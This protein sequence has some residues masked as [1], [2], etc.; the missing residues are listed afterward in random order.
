MRKGFLWLQVALSKGAWVMRRVFSSDCRLCY[1][2]VAWVMRKGFLWLQIV[3]SK[4]YLMRSFFL[5]L[6]IALSKGYLMR[7]GFLWLQIALSKGCLMRRVFLW[8]QIALSKGCSRLSWAVLDWN[9]PSIE[10]YKRRGGINLT[11]KEGWHLFRMTKPVMEDFVAQKES[12]SWFLHVHYM[13]SSKVF[14]VTCHFICFLGCLSAA[15]HRPASV[16]QIPTKNSKL[17]LFTFRYTSFQITAYSKARQSK[18]TLC[19]CLWLTH[20]PFAQ[21]IR[22]MIYEECIM[23]N[24]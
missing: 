16:G 8:L 12:K 1:Q 4:G 6:Q 3:L 19:R 10:L 21:V 20:T 24:T 18:E 2:R 14:S 13:Y 22:Y 5:W 23:Q 17:R 9:T 15:E 7:R 11:E